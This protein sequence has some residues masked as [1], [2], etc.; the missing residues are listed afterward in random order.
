M[1]ILDDLYEYGKI[2]SLEL[3]TKLRNDFKDPTGDLFAEKNGIKPE[4]Q[5]VDILKDKKLPVVIV[6]DIC[7][8]TLSKIGFLPSI[9]IIDNKTLRHQQIDPFLPNHDP[10]ALIYAKNPAGQ[11]T[12]E[13]IKAIQRGLDLNAELKETILVKVEGE[14]DLLV[15]PTA[16]LSPPGSH[17]IYGQPG[18]GMVL[19]KVTNSIQKSFIGLL[20]KFIKIHKPVNE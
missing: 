20:K 11:V 18:E 3:P 14:E 5:V 17:V 15:L 6:G 12:F 9:A 8:I 19:L 2:W 4:E 10:R 16:I 7:A 13:A 1:D